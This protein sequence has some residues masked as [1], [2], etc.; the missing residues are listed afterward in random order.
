[1]FAGLKILKN[2]PGSLVFD[3]RSFAW[4]DWGYPQ[5]LFLQGLSDL[6]IAELDK[7][8]WRFSITSNSEVSGRL[9]MCEA[10]SPRHVQNPLSD[11]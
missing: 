3:I 4:D 9:G 7:R 5:L 1:M 11:K 8:P 2:I 6:R 10:K